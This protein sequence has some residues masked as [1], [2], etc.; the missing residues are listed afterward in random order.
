M[1]TMQYMADEAVWFHANGDTPTA[2][3][4][5]EKFFEFRDSMQATLSQV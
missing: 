3:K 5:E 4:I 1:E 2:L